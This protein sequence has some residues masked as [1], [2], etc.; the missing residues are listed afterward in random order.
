LRSTLPSCIPGPC[1]AIHNLHLLGS[2]RA[3]NVNFSSPVQHNVKFSSPVQHFTN[4]QSV[5]CARDW[6]I[7]SFFWKANHFILQ[8]ESWTDTVHLV[9]YSSTPPIHLPGRYAYHL[10]NA[11][12]RAQKR[13]D[14]RW[15]RYA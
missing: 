12:S 3:D 13:R 15:S 7:S 10:A 11:T 2:S 5:K 4:N 6:T 14:W 8:S 9:N 1:T